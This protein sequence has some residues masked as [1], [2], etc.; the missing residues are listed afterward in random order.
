MPLQALNLRDAEIRGT[1]RTSRPDQTIDHAWSAASEKPSNTARWEALPL[2][3]LLCQE[4]DGE[5]GVPWSGW[6]GC[7]RWQMRRARWRLR[8]RMASLVLLPS[9]RLRAM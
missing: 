9:E 2:S 4:I 8:Q 5:G 1:P 7:R 3:L 6:G